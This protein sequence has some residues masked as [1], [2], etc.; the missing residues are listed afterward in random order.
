[1]DPGMAHT[2]CHDAVKAA[3]KELGLDLT[4][5]G[6]FITHHNIDHFGLVPQLMVKESI[7]YINHTEKVSFARTHHSE[8]NFFE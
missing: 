6:F 1:V 5:T 3:V 7:I 4:R 2:L 8:I